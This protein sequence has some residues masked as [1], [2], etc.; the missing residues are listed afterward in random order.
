ML[1]FCFHRH[2]AHEQCRDRLQTVR[3]DSVR[4]HHPA[5]TLND[6]ANDCTILSITSFDS[7]RSA[8]VGAPSYPATARAIN[9]PLM[10]RCTARGRGRGCEISE[11]C[12][13]QPDRR[14][15][16]SY[17]LRLFFNLYLV[18]TTLS[19]QCRCPIASSSKHNP[20]HLFS[21]PLLQLTF[22]SFVS[23]YPHPP[24]PVSFVFSTGDD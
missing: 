4:W 23:V 16:G 14:C 18:S 24:P 8:T 10:A 6:T 12:T 1:Y 11:W 7:T 9:M 13:T 3:S 2:R 19:H 21:T 22:S 5:S 15:S 17:T 20:R